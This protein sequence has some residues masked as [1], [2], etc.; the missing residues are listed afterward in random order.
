MALSGDSIGREYGPV[1]RQRDYN[2]DHHHD[3]DHGHVS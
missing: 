1:L 2:D 3:H